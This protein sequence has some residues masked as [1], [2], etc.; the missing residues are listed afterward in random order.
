MLKCVLK[1]L[2]PA[3]LLR[4]L[5]L[6]ASALCFAVPLSLWSSYNPVVVLPDPILEDHPSLLCESCQQPLFMVP[7]TLSTTSFL[8]G[9]LFAVTLQ[10]VILNGILCLQC[11][12]SDRGLELPY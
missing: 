7:A 8:P 6:V 9:L 3:G 1:E 5:K 10:L 12:G 11:T 2:R 4:P